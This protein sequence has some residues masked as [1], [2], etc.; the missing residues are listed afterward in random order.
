MK[1]SR[2]TVISWVVF[3]GCGLLASSS[4][5]A[6]SLDVNIASIT[7]PAKEPTLGLRQSLYVRQPGPGNSVVTDQ[8][9]HRLA[10]VIKLGSVRTRDDGIHHTSVKGSDWIIKVYDD[11]NTFRFMR[12]R[13]TTYRLPLSQKPSQSKVLEDGRRI[14]MK[15]LADIVK[16]DGNE[17]I[18]PVAIK[19]EFEGSQSADRSQPPI[20]ELAGWTAVF[21]RKIDGSRVAGG[22]SRIAMS[23]DARGELTGIVVDWPRYTTT[24]TYV[25]TV[26]KTEVM[27]RAMLSESIPQGGV[28]K[29]QENL[30]CGMLDPGGRHNGKRSRYLQPGCMYRAV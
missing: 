28:I 13:P 1:T 27:R 20:V 14:L 15:V 12:D 4:A 18:V 5:Q 2:N 6:S 10:P 19:G 26:G 22:G 23:F 17:Q 3:L 21:G 11:G 25:T 16:V 9:L 30:D 24:K 8:L 7:V 29:R